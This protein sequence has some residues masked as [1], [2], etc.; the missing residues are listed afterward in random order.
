MNTRTNIVLDD[1]LIAKAMARAHVSTKKAAVEAALR[2]FVREPDYSA[3]L[4]LEGSRL[5]SDDYDPKGAYMPS[6][7]TALSSPARAAL[8]KQSIAKKAKAPAPD[9]KRRKKAYA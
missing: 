3:L 7:P 4:A 9:S 6:T 5:I 2:A 8:G 1:E